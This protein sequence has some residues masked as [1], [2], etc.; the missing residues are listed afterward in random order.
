MQDSKNSKRE[1]PDSDATSKETLDDLEKSGQVSDSENPEHDSSPSPD[2]QLD[3]A[4]GI[5]DAGPV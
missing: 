4:D 3:E 2:G 1:A 5:K